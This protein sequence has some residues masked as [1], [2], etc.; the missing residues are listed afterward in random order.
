MINKKRLQKGFT[1]IE[2]MVAMTIFV[3]FIGVIVQSYFGIIVMQRESN[4]YRVMY[5]EAR[6]IFDKFSDE[7]R[8]GGISYAQTLAVNS[9]GTLTNPLSAIVLFSPDFSRAV[10]F[11][12][13][14][15]SIAFSEASIVDGVVTVKDSYNLNSDRIRIKEFRIYISPLVDPYSSE[16][17]YNNVVQYQPKVTIFVEFE[18][19]ISGGKTLD[20]DLQTTISSRNY[21]PGYDQVQSVFGSTIPI[22]SP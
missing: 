6:Y 13:D 4:E 16:N 11:K 5:S 7:V 17:V 3:I 2:M 18:K 21:T 20:L 22:S 8:N 19:D 12:H 9:V 10:M 14:G 1:L 15:E